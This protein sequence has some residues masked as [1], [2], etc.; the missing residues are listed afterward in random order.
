MNGFKFVLSRESRKYQQMSVINSREE[1]SH[2]LSAMTP[3]L[4]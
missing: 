3:L 4:N 1:W 2:R